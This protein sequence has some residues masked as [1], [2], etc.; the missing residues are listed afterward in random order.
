MIGFSAGGHLAYLS[1]C[2]LS[3][4]FTAVLY[5]GWLPTTD[6]PMSRPTP[7]LDLTPGITGHLLYAVG[8]DDALINAEQRNQIRAALERA[9]ISHEVVSYPNAQH[10]F[11]WRDTPMFNQEAS[12]DTWA[13][14]LSMLAG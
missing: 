6:I 13:R 12:D 9:N 1:A 5:G 10:A 11:F 8:E 3:I 4:N 14:I 7:T 2:Q